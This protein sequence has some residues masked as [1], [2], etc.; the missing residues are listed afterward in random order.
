MYMSFTL[1]QKRRKIKLQWKYLG[2]KMKILH[3]VTL[4]NLPCFFFFKLFNFLLPIRYVVNEINFP[5]QP[6]KWP[7]FKRRKR[8]WIYIST[9]K[10]CHSKKLVF[11]FVFAELKRL[12]GTPPSHPARH[13]ENCRPRDSV[14]SQSNPL[15]RFIL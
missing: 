11:Y 1:Q 12:K 3:T 14:N 2:V 7:I 15:N 8:R 4:N 9:R 13:P 6:K 5:L 10:L